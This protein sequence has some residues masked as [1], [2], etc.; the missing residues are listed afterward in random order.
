M[1]LPA[2]R[3]AQA[4]LAQAAA[5]AVNVRATLRQAAAVSHAPAQNMCALK[6]HLLH[7]PLHQASTAVAEAIAQAV[8][9]TGATHRAAAITEAARLRGVP[10]Q[11]RDVVQ[12]AATVAEA[13]VQVQAQAVAV[14]AQVVVAIAPLAVAAV[15]VVVEDNFRATSID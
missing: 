8:P 11:V 12:V 13:A 9:T 1:S 14:A 10:L 3:Q 5:K 15:Q 6:A 4:M 2:V 7:A